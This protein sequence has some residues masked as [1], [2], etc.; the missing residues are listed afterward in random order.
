MRNKSIRLVNFYRLIKDINNL[1]ENKPIV[2]FESLVLKSASS[3]GIDLF[4]DKCS[5]IRL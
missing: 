1:S 4:N 5:P 2:W 3:V